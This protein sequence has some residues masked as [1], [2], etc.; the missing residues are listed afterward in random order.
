MVN[1]YFFFMSILS[2]SFFI[3]WITN[4]PEIF[5]Y[6]DMSAGNLYVDGNIT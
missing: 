3:D 6:A 5:N 2:V 4:G 1:K